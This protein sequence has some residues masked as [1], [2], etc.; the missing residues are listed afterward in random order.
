MDARIVSMPEKETV[1]LW[2]LLTGTHWTL[3]LL[4]G[5]GPT[6]QTWEGLTAAAAE[7]ARRNL[8]AEVQTHLVAVEPP[9]VVIP[10]ARLHLDRQLFLHRRYGDGAPGLYLLRPD[11][12]VGFRGR[13]TDASALGEY[14]DSVFTPALPRA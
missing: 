14:L 13:S 11:R 5:T 2:D 9:G 12:Y 3:L 6:S 8:A 7:V 10:G 1:R 4:A